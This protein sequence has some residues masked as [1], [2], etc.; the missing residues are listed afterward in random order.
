MTELTDLARKLTTEGANFATISTLMPDGSPQTSIVW[1]DSDEGHILINTAE[2][3]VKT[4]N[5]LRDPRVAV[6]VFNAEAPAEH[7]SIRGRV[8]EVTREGAADH[9]DRLAKKYMGVDR[10]P[11]H[12]D[13]EQRIIVKIAPDRISG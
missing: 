7:V 12:R 8:V 1:I 13:D 10:Y 6:T 9:I 4:I 11:Y 3:R 5:F 2:G